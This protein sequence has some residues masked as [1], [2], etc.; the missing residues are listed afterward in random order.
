MPQYEYLCKCGH[1]TTDWQMMSDRKETIKCAACGKQAKYKFS[2]ATVVAHYPLG[3][4]RQGRGRR[5]KC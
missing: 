5:G 3:H 2:A 4:P 1:V